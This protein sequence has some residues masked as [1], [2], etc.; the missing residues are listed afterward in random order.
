MSPGAGSPFRDRAS[1][2]L[3]GVTVLQ[4]VADLDSGA[5][6]QAAIGT[7]AALSRAGAH[8]LIASRGGALISELQARGGL[9]TPFPAHVRNPLGM[10]L[11]I[12]RLAQL[13]EAERVDLVHARSR[14]AAWVAYGATRLARTPFV[15]SF[16][17]SY[18]Q[19][20]PLALRYN[21]VMARGDAVIA[22]SAFTAGIV[23]RLFPAAR[24]RLH[25]VVDGVDCRLFTPKAVA[26]ARV[27]AVRRLWGAAQDERIVYVAPAGPTSAAAA[28]IEA[29]RRLSL[30]ADAEALLG[31]TT[32]LVACEDAGGAAARGIDAAIARAGL[33]QI[34]RTGAANPDRPAALLTAAVAVALPARPDGLAGLALEAQA[35]GAP[36]VVAATGAASETIL[37]PPD[38][39]DSARTGWRT[40]LDPEAVAAALRAALSLGATARERLS[41]RARA[42]V[43][44]RFSIEQT[45]AQTL[46]AYAQAR[47]ETR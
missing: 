11:N 22:D 34:M 41:L 26:P 30:E 24:N 33:Q 14:A 35:M 43:E 47:A 20:G 13:I 27:Q 37:A 2:P 44:A 29:I 32:F 45:F 8:A 46:A 40:S 5:V 39:A 21:S 31:G 42:H 36:L 16:R 28:L 38:V 1:H 12:R 9:F 6:A 3:A 19:G 25:I 23:A 15:T 4:I 7:A 17:G 10:A 18:A